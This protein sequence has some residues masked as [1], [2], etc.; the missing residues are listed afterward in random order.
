MSKGT[1]IQ[2]IVHV[3]PSV[4][5]WLAK[6]RREFH[7]IHIVWSGFHHVVPDGGLELSQ[8]QGSL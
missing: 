3:L 4:G 5:M 1:Q 8:G 6:G 7:E 2:A